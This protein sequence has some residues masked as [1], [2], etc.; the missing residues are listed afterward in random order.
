VCMMSAKYST[1]NVEG[2]LGEVELDSFYVD[3]PVGGK[4][5]VKS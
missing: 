1:Y 5:G 3:V 2:C 4:L